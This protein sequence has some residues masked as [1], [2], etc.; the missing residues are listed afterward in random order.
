MRCLAKELN[1]TLY[2]SDWATEYRKSGY[3]S[4]KQHLCD[5]LPKAK[6][7]VECRD[8]FTGSSAGM[9][10]GVKT[11]GYTS[12]YKLSTFNTESNWNK[13]DAEGTDPDSEFWTWALGFPSVFNPTVNY[14][15]KNGTYN[16]AS[17]YPF[18]PSD[19]N[20]DHP[21]HKCHLYPELYTLYLHYAGPEYADYLCTMGNYGFIGD[22]TTGVDS[23][24]YIGSATEQGWNMRGFNEM[25]EGYP[26][27]SFTEF[28]I[29][30]TYLARNNK[31]G[32]ATTYS[33]DDAVKSINKPAGSNVFEIITVKGQVVQADE[34]V[35]ATEPDALK[36]MTGNVVDKL[37]SQPQF[38]WPKPVDGVTIAL[39]W[40]VN[41]VGFDWRK[42]ITKF[43]NGVD[44]EHEYRSYR[45]LNS[46]SCMNRIELLNTP[47]HNS[48]MNVMRVVYTDSTCIEN[49]VA[50]AR[51]DDPTLSKTSDE[52]GVVNGL[53]VNSF[54]GK[55]V[56]R[57]LRQLFEGEANGYG[58]SKIPD[59]DKVVFNYEPYMWFYSTPG[60][61]YSM[62]EIHEW[63]KQP[64]KDDKK[65]I[66][67]QQAWNMK[68][69]GW[70][71]GSIKQVRQGLL[72]MLGA[73]YSTQ[74]DIYKRQHCNDKWFEKLDKA[75]EC[76]KA[77]NLHESCD[78]WVPEL[79]KTK[80]ACGNPR[81]TPL[82]DCG[83]SIWDYDTPG[84]DN[85]GELLE[86]EVH[87]TGT[88][89]CPAADAKDQKLKWQP[90]Y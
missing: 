34:V 28:C 46:D 3:V 1:I 52:W 25:D 27:G 47:Y 42:N 37:T 14:D 73:A 68:Y 41:T 55:E 30:P 62:K 70:A 36:Y 22:C 56:V 21:R 17:P 57:E 66:L 58:I 4:Y 44:T 43:L 81:R 31:N 13:N 79:K 75:S 67:A 65:I 32:V 18:D 69:S 61:K 90:Q 20:Q 86:N 35:V 45:M 78:S 48:G 54:I 76:S 71:L 85:L 10:S 64:L 9:V 74:E 89:N 5:A 53:G 6:G 87:C 77:G 19:L 2:Y 39:H 23:C 33:Y 82:S 26:V 29:R 80:L 40:D 7:S 16:N 59:P 63:A 12:A 8:G 24:T 83:G 49:L 50:L 38:S 60:N 88:T 84:Q 72:N 51:I 11:P 15:G